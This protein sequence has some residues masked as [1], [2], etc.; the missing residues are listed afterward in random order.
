MYPLSTID[1]YHPQS[2]RQK[3]C[4]YA[5]FD[6]SSME[7]I[8]RHSQ[9][10]TLP[11]QNIA[12]PL[13]RSPRKMQLATN[14]AFSHRLTTGDYRKAI[15]LTRSFPGE[16]CLSRPGQVAKTWLPPFVKSCHLDRWKS[17]QRLLQP[18]VLHQ[19]TADLDRQQRSG[20]SGLRRKRPGGPGLAVIRANRRNHKGRWR[21]GAARTTG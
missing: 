7:R 11:K 16:R 14:P 21:D 3:S 9:I 17:T 2:Q 19:S 8:K 20:P 18:D 5:G 10:K 12:V 4:V 13:N 1:L 6:A 15:D